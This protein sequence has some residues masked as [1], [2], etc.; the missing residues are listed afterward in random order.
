M[1]QLVA[2]FFSVVAFALG[3]MAQSIPAELLEVPVKLAVDKPMVEAR[4]GS[5]V[6]YTITLKNARNQTVV[7]PAALQIEVK[8]PTGRETVSLPAEHSSVTFN[9]RPVNS[10]VAHISVQAGKL[11]PATAL[12][13][14][15]PSTKAL[16]PVPP[17]QEQVHAAPAP[18]MMHEF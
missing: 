16:I 4:A 10:G 18:P 8:T 15:L 6:T 3:T 2:I 11:R 17:K 7:A 5:T 1:A 12:V 9:W 13:L 14:V